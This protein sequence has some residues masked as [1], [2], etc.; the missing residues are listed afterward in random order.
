MAIKKYWSFYHPEDPKESFIGGMYL[1]GILTGL[2][3]HVA[4]IFDISFL[5]VLIPLVAIFVID[6]MFFRSKK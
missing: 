1:G 5:A 4:G 3:I 2:G 6:M